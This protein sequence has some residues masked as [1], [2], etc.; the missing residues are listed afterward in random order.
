MNRPRLDFA[1]IRE[2]PL[3]GVLARYNISLK[4]KD[5]TALYGNCPL[6]SH[7]SRTKGSFFVNTT[8]NVWYC[9]SDSCKKGSR[10]GGNVIDFVAVM[11]KLDAY[12]AAARLAE[13]FPLEQ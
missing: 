12:A 1:A 2:I 3:E 13:W 4:R 10:A 9:H 5:G 7:G 6:P 8:R 11:E